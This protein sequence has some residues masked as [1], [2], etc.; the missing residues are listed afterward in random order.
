MTWDAFHHR[1][2]VLRAVIDEAD[3]RQDGTLPMHVDGVMHTFRDELDLVAALQL[4]WHTRLAGRIESALANE[5]MDLE[6]AVVEAWGQVAELMPGVRMI[7]DAAERDDD[8]TVRRPMTVAADKERAM[9][10]VMAGQSSVL[11]DRAAAVG[12]RI[13][14]RART[15]YEQA[16]HAHV[17][18]AETAEGSRPEKPSAP[19][20]RPRSTFVD[21]LKAAV[22]VA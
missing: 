4:R 3:A 6:S 2:A 15:A 19:P 22:A 14:E 5:P 9:L 17:S 10:A 8:E 12:A 7:L 16:D 18:V 1:G 20:A 11:D 21:R 13:E